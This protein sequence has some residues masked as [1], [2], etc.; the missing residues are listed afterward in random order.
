MTGDRLEVAASGA[1]TTI[2]GHALEQLVG[3]VPGE[4]PALTVDVA[5]LRELDT[6]GAALLD[7][8]LRSYQARGREARLVGLPSKFERLYGEGRR[9]QGEPVP[10][11]PPRE[12]GPVA[13]VIE[14]GHS[15]VNV[16]GSLAAIVD[17]F[18]AL[19]G[20]LARVIVRPQTF[21]FTSA[22][23]HLDRVGWQ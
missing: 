3:A 8:L 1:W 23:H 19:G 2:H 10:A 15:V 6:L 16:G 13:A 7:R 4:A 5:G 21:R 12:R 20:A 17:M 22:I 11:E 9:A 14:I 18:G